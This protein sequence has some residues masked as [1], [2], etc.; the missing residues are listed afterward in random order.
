MF[1]L[2]EF[3]AVQ[4]LDQADEILHQ[5]KKNVVLGGLLWMRMG[6]RQ[7]H[8][9]ID[10]GSLG[11]DQI[12]DTGNAIDIGCYT[13]LR[14]METSALLRDNFG[15]LFQDAL[16]SI[17]GIQFRNLA[18]IGGSVFS[19]FSF[20]DLTTALMVLD[21]QVHL[22][23]GGTLALADFLDAP[24]GRDILVKLSIPKKSIKTAYQSIRMTATDFPVLATALSFSQD[25]WKIALGSRPSRA[26]LARETAAQ[27]TDYPSPE[28]IRS[29]CDTL[30]DELSF[31]GN[32]RGSKAYREKLARVLV[33]RGIDSICR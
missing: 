32:Q 9:G 4:S 23:R 20:S 6:T 26:K 30:M 3:R 11:L 29:A 15:S 24:P 13:C 31:G 8:T 1:E 28:Q 17:V 21:T 27:L 10:L 25:G 7:F 19:R 22:H 12:V 18:T 14:Q 2:K 16:G 33:K 5:N